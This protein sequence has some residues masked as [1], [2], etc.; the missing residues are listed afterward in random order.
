[1][2][3]SGLARNVTYEIWH[4][5]SDLYGTWTDENNVLA[6]TFQNILLYGL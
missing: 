6:L 4:E 2:Q 1:M 5:I 3:E